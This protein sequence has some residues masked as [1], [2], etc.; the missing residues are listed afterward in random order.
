MDIK[1]ITV[2]GGGSMGHGIVQVCAQSGFN[3]C[4]VSGRFKEEAVRDSLAKIKK[5]LQG[6]VER[7]KMTQEQADDIM[8]RIKG[9]ANLKEGVQNSDFIIEAIGENLEIKHNLFKQVDELAP[10]HAI[11]ASNTSYQSITEIASVT[12][13]LDKFVGTHWF[14]PPQIMRGVEV[15]LTEKTSKETLDT[16]VDLCKKLGK[17]PA[18]CSDSPGFIANHLLG[19]WRNE[20]YKLY[21]RRVASMKD[22][23]TAFKVGY[24]FRMGQFE[25]GDLAGL[26]VVLVGANTLYKELGKEIFAP[27]HCHAMKVRAG[28]YGRKTGRGFYEYK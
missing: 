28:N 9:T 15:V 17:E 23:D 14:N 8:G 12:K 22:I 2:I 20:A 1:Q 25:L 21:D 11:F 3:V 7:Q 5:F 19:V 13:R 6:S 27:A 16:T 18:V 10:P 24:N 26:D 4:L